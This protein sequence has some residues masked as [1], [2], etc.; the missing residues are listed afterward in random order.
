MQ[1]KEPTEPIHEDPIRIVESGV[2]WGHIAGQQAVFFFQFEEVFQQ[3]AESAMCIF[4]FRDCS[5]AGCVSM[6][7]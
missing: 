5:H 6:Q 3:C 1:R 7:K 2:R 4:H